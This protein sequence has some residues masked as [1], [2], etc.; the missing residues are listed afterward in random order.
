MTTLLLL[1]IYLAFISLGLPDSMLGAAWPLMRSELGLP[2]EGAGLVSVIITVGTIISSLLTGRLIRK[3]GTGRL[4]T[5]S[6]LTTAL[7]LLGYSFTTSYL[8]LCLMAVPMGLGAGAV[9]ASLNDFVARNYSSKHMSWLHAF[10]GVGATAGPLLM[11]G[12]ISLTGRWQNGYRSVSF[13]QF[14]LVAILIASLSLWKKFDHASAEAHSVKLSNGSI[15][16]IPGMGPNLAAFFAYCSLELTAGLWFASYLV[17]IR[18]VKPE[19]AAAWAASY[20]FGIMLGRMI[21]GFL[22]RRFSSKTLI[23]AGQTSILLG[24]L[25]LF[26]PG[27]TFSLIGLLLVGMGCAPIYPSMLHETPARFGKENSSRL[28]GIQMASAYV[29]LSVAPPLVGLLASRWSLQIFP[30]ALLILLALMVWGSETV[31]RVVTGKEADT[32]PL[33]GDTG[34]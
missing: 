4:T 14:G 13:V 20:Y 27:N 30:F 18:G 12:M 16:K 6:V 3:L 7:A 31:N 23:R 26:L 17:Q 19:T 25:L 1:V 10:W 8:W 15:W 11:A 22:T 2:L 28:M 33:R 9:D 21:N 34:S 24:I 32:R 29:G 5:L